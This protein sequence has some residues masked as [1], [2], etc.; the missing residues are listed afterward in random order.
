M[1]RAGRLAA[2]DRHDREALFAIGE[3]GC[4]FQEFGA[5]GLAVMAAKS[6]CKPPARPM[7]VG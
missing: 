3:S 6:H 7:L 4:E 2:N 5:H 1:S